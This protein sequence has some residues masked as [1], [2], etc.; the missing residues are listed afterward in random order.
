M[1]VRAC[2]VV[3]AALTALACGSDAQC[4]IDTDCDLGLRCNADNRCVPRGAGDAMVDA[5]PVDAGDAGEEDATVDSPLPDSGPENVGT[6]FVSLT[7]EEI[8]TGSPSYSTFA[9]FSL[10]DPDA[11]ESPCTVSME[12]PCRMTVCPE[13]VPMDAGMP[14]AGM[15]AAVDAGPMVAPNAGTI[16]VSGGTLALTLTPDAMGVYPPQTGTMRLWPDATTDLTI[17][18]MLGADV[19]MFGADVTGVVAVTITAPPLSGEINR[20][21]DLPVSWTGTSAGEVILTLFAAG[22]MGASTTAEC[23]FDPPSF[24]G[25]VP[26]SALAAFPAGGS[27]SISIRVQNTVVVEEGGWTVTLTTN[28]NALVSDGVVASG[29]VTFSL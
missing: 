21:A 19:P 25:T 23:R 29:A 1:V 3:C 20:A 16:Q 14:D 26:A 17:R 4:A 2:L 12:G 24:T 5:P 8:F 15:D 9:G 10:I 11:P 7:S 18:S 28:A 22:A 13:M 27:G 6:G